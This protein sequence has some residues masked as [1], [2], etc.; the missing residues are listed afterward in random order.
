MTT[1]TTTLE[2]RT[3]G[4]EEVAEAIT[5]AETPTDASNPV[6]GLEVGKSTRDQVSR[7][8]GHLADK[9]AEGEASADPEAEE[10]AAEGDFDLPVLAAQES[11]LTGRDAR[12]RALFEI[13]DL[14]RLALKFPKAWA[15][16]LKG[17]E[18]KGRTIEAQVFDLVV[19]TDPEAQPRAIGEISR[20]RRATYAGAIG[21]FAFMCEGMGADEAIEALKASGGLEGGASVS[22]CLRAELDHGRAQ[23]PWH[24]EAARASRGVGQAEGE[25][26]TGG[27][28]A[29]CR[30]HVRA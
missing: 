18:V 26:G 22:E 12:Y 15:E 13:A 23:I 17:K 19:S 4:R 6:T 1:D 16:Y 30:D 7:V 10:A 28:A 25:A 29:C 21:Y 24:R 2:R 8:L 11:W 3:T 27:G 14:L 9:A 5:A 20:D